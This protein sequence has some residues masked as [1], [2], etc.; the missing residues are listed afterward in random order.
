MPQGTVFPQNRDVNV[1]MTTVHPQPFRRLGNLLILNKVTAPST[2]QTP[3]NTTRSTQ[4]TNG[5]SEQDAGTTPLPKNAN[6]VNQTDVENGVLMRKTDSAS[7]ATYRELTSAEAAESEGYDASTDVYKSVDAYFKQARPSDRVAV[8][9]YVDKKLD[10]AL[11]AFWNQNF[12]F[13][14]FATPGITPDA[15]IVSNDCEANKDHFV[16]LQSNKPDDFPQLGGQNF[17]IGVVHDLSERMDVAL[18]GS[19][20]NEP[21]GSVTWKFKELT[22]ITPQDLSVN[23]LAAINKVRGIAYETVNGEPQ[24]SEGKVLSG[25]YI[26]AIHG[27]IW[28]QVHMASALQK[29]LH[30]NDKIPYETKGINMILATGTQVLEQ[31]YEQGIILTDEVSSKGD[32]SIT[33]SP[34]S[35]QSAA[36]L[37]NRHYGGLSF[38]YHMSGAI[39]TITVYGTVDSDT[40]IQNA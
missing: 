29:L 28:V 38:K 39:H 20:A 9:D 35:A 37:S 15:T 24:T 34:R 22:G 14:V 2:P 40:I 19:I 36:D 16:V 5:T 4:G 10:D 12:T 18:V 1:I 11:Q 21:V 27:E 33:A 13:I 8:L 31:A 23:E 3:G 26:D 7:G 6:G 32:Y 17:T 25:E 30:D